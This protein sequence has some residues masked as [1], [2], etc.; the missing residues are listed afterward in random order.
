M[1]YC[2]I[3]YGEDM[4]NHFLAL[5]RHAVAERGSLTSASLTSVYCLYFCV[6]VSV[7]VLRYMSVAELYVLRYM[8]V[9]E[10]YVVRPAAAPHPACGTAGAA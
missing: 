5:L 2:A 8:S 3:R 4:A 1:S 9:T 6:R 10:F 7:C